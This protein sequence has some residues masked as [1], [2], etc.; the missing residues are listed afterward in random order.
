MNWSWEFFFAYL[1]NGMMMRGAWTTIWL[2]VISMILGLGLGVVAAMMKMYGNRALRWTAEFYIWL[3]R[4]TPILIQLV[5]IYTGLPQLGIRL[6]VIE[7]A[8]LGLALNEGAYLAEVMRSGIM[9]V[10]KGQTDASRAI[11]MTW[12]QRMWLVIIPQATRTIIP[13]LGNQFN[14]MLKTTSLASVISM[15]ELMRSA[16]MLA[17]TEFRVLE[18]YVVAAVWYLVLVS[19]WGLV[20]ARIE[21]HYE[22]PFGPAAAVSPDAKKD[23]EKATQLSGAT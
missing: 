17:Q 14:G 16:Q 12:R 3:F 4:G 13:P 9:S 2:S 19:I 1:T 8:I 7:S 10:D 15:E 6:N 23:I 5:I 21:A 18:A 22:K 20:Q 11:G